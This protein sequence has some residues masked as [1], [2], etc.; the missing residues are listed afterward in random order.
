M[1]MLNKILVDTKKRAIKIGDRTMLM[2][3][4]KRAEQFL[5]SLARDRTMLMLNRSKINIL[6]LHYNL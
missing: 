2:L 1:L 5:S 4:F 3:N 6:F